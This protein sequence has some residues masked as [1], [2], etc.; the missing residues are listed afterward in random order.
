M[1]WPPQSSIIYDNQLNFA[2]QSRV[3]G[4]G[5]RGIRSVSFNVV[6]TCE[7]D[8]W[9]T[10]N[11]LLISGADGMIVSNQN[12]GVSNVAGQGG[13]ASQFCGLLQTTPGANGWLNASGDGYVNNPS[14]QDIGRVRALAEGVTLLRVV[15]LDRDGIPDTSPLNGMEMAVPEGS[16]AP[17]ERDIGQTYFGA[18]GNWVDVFRFRYTKTGF[19][20]CPAAVEFSVQP[21]GMPTLFDTMQ[22]VSGTWMARSVDAMAVRAGSVVVPLCSGGV[23]C[24]ADHDGNGSIDANDIF[25]FINDWFEG[26]AGAGGFW[27]STRT[28]DLNCNGL[29]TAD[30][31]FIYLERWFAG[32]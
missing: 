3:V 15:D 24:K 32:C 5:G 10:L 30:D 17:L 8:S 13:L 28:A 16:V 31:I 1:P 22:R 29:L 4:S 18:D 26:C 11:R 2:V 21:V 25:L 27:C 14:A 23:A 12:Q 20:G 9:G 19:G 7:R 6:A